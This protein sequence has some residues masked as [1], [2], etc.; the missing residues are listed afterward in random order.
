[1]IKQICSSNTCTIQ[2]E[3]NGIIRPQPLLE[4]ESFRTC[5]DHYCDRYVTVSHDECREDAL[6]PAPT[7]RLY[8]TIVS[9]A[10]PLSVMLSYVQEPQIERLNLS[11][12]LQESAER[13]GFLILSVMGVFRRCE[14][15]GVVS[16]L[17]S[18]PGSP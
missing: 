8:A 6:L 7:R 12:P 4:L 2:K 10:T 1:M 11:S 17:T 15:A 5:R 16:T 14:A 9:S 18:D 3:R 13:Y